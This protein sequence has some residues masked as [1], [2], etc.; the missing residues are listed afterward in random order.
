MKNDDYEEVFLEDDDDFEDD[1]LYEL[2]PR[3]SYAILFIPDI[4]AL[5]AYIWF[6]NHYL[7]MASFLIAACGIVNSIKVLAFHHYRLF[8]FCI[9]STVVSLIG[10]IFIPFSG[11]YKLVFWGALLT[12][13]WGRRGE[14][15]Y[16][17]II[18]PFSNLLI[19]TGIVW[20]IINI[21]F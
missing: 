2:E 1:D 19:L 13:I 5:A 9:I 10:S 4:L 17:R 16:E 6:D 14:P 8:D 7:K 3:P 18:N 20:G 11:A 21:I 15:I 12:I